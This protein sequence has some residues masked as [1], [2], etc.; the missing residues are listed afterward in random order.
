MKKSS[1]NRFYHGGHLGDLVCSLYGIMK[2]G[3]G[4][5]YI[6]P[7]NHT[8]WNEGLQKA[9]VSLCAHQ[10]YI[11]HAER[12]DEKPDG[13]T[14][15]FTQTWRD[16]KMHQS[17]TTGIGPHF[18]YH[19]SIASCGLK[20]RDLINL[21]KST[22]TLREILRMLNHD[23]PWLTAPET[24]SYD[25]VCHLPHHKICRSLQEWKQIFEAIYD[26]GLS[27]ALIGA[28]DVEEWG[29]GQAWDLVKP[30]DLLDAADYIN[31]AKL[32]IGVSSVNNA[33]A[34]GLDQFRFIE[35][36]E[37]W[38]TE[39]QNERGWKINDWNLERITHSVKLLTEPLRHGK[40]QH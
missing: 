27:V 13:L 23:E 39:P 19:T 28:G 16:Q 25:V 9:A 34:E 4:E 37:A 10:P 20:K 33:I 26:L 24:K 31:S 6:G 1:T 5:I 14:Y 36:R 11:T 29:E 40:N 30:C 22:Y 15:D 3:G 21:F 8:H 12:V 2:L 38:G 32:F 7:H 35:C 18:E 17:E